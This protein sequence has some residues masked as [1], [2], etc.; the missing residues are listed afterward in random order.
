[1]ARL[2]CCID[3]QDFADHPYVAALQGFK[4][5][6]VAH[7]SSGRLVHLPNSAEPE[8]ILAQAEYVRRAAAIPRRTGVART[9]HGCLMGLESPEVPQ[10]LDEGGL[11]APRIV[12]LAGVFFLAWLCLLTRRFAGPNGSTLVPGAKSEGCR[13]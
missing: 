3:G 12:L 10:G 2:T 4:G 7:G 13:V 5:L 8:L 9:V 11:Q 6:Q 1:M